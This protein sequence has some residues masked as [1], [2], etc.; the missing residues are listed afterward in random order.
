LSKTA[1]KISSTTRPRKRMTAAARREVIERAALDVFAERGY[2]GA[3]IDE[4]AR[5]SGVTAPVVYDHFASKLDLFKRLL[6][7]T[8]DELLELW[9]EQLGGDEPAEQRV[10][11][12]LDA[13]ARY[14]ELHPFAPRVFFTKTTGDPD[15]NAIHQEVGAQAV[16]ALGP[17][18]GGEEGAEY[19][20]GADPEALE[21]AAEVIR[22]GLTG[23]AIWWSEH[24][25]VP[26]EQ[27]VATAINTLWIGFERVRLGETWTAGSAAGATGQD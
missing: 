6:E 9:R 10:P 23:L 3:S 17:I 12:A 22:A 27:I 18:L 15:V 21:M 5:R 14:V 19:I 1:S 2:H 11:R 26:R 4:I 13:W 16:A 25:H 7:R 20:A 24:P 8:R